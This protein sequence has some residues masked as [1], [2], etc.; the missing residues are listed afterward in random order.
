MI[1]AEFSASLLINIVI[2]CSVVWK[3]FCPFIQIDH[4]HDLQSQL[5]VSI[6]EIRG[7][8]R[9]AVKQEDAASCTSSYVNALR[10]V[11]SCGG[12]EVKKNNVNSV[13]FLAQTDRFVS[14]DFDVSSRA[15]GLFWFCLCMF[16]W[17][18]KPWVP[19]TAIIWLTDCNGLS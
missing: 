17:L 8:L 18:S 2:Y 14:L 13:Q 6:W 3:S 4:W 11:G 16:F 1:K 15:G 12:S 10:R 7:G 19:L 9:F 5:G